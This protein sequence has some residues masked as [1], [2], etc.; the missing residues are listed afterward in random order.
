MSGTW[1]EW[2]AEHTD[3]TLKALMLQDIPE[4]M[5]KS[6][7]LDAMAIAINKLLPPILGAMVNEVRVMQD[8]IDEIWAFLKEEDDE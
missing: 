5:K 3:N 7:T 8:Q 2:V 6:G 4:S 1:A